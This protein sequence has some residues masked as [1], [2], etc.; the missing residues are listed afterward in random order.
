[1]LAQT[2]TNYVDQLRLTRRPGTVENEDEAL[3]EFGCFLA[4]E[5]PAVTSAA[6]V[7]RGHVEAY[8][9]WLGERPSRYGGQLHRHT[10]RRQ[11]NSVQLCFQRLIEW[12]AEDAPPRAPIFPSDL[13][14][15]DTALPRFLDDAAAA[16]LLVAARA[17]TDPVVRLIAEFLARTGMRKS[18]LVA[19]TTDAVVQIGSAYWLRIPVAKLHN[20][21]YIPLHPQ[22]KELLDS[23]LDSRPDGLRSKLMF[24]ERGRAM[25]TARVDAAVDRVARAAGLETTSHPTACATRWPPRPSTE[26]CRSKRS[27]R[28]SAIAP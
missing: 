1:M 8:K 19:L 16:K 10:I 17:D 21:R 6:Q 11:L 27:P 28:C 3:R 20:D 18:E 12:G 9:R 2:L 22:L 4:R 5:H 24:I 23:W 25:S 7:G 15:K 26:E 14:I 13:P